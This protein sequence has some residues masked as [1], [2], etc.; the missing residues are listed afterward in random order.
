M[1]TIILLK[2]M[3]WEKEAIISK[4]LSVFVVDAKK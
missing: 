2:A 3:N 1:D 4:E